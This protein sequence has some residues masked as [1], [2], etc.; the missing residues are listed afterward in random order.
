MSSPEPEIAVVGAG[1]FVGRR[2][3]EALAAAGVRVVACGRRGLELPGVGIAP[4]RV[5]IADAQDRAA[6]AR[7]VAGARVVV[8]AAGPLR[9]T[10]APVLEAALAAGAHYVDVGGEQAVLRSLYERY[11]SAVRK[12]GLVALPGAGLD[13]LIGDLAVAWAAAHLVGGAGDGDGAVGGAAGDGAVGGDGAG[14]G[15]PAV[16]DAPAPRLADA[17]PFD[18]IAVTYAFDDL[19]VSP[20]TQRAWFGVLGERALIWRRDRWEPARPGELRRVNAGPDLGGERA[21]IAHAGGDAITVPRHVAAH[22]VATYLSTTRRPS[23]GSALRLLSLAL[24]LLPRTASDVLVPYADPH[25]DYAR[26]RFAVIAQVRRD[27]AAAHVIVRGADPYR[28]TAVAAA[29]AARALAARGAG[30]VGMRAPGELFRGAPALRELAALA[31][32]VLE[33][34]FD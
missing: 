15:A 19:A 33:P 30:P 32:L 28:T 25:A 31:D 11:E 6:L 26:T 16:R 27:F 3:V 20:G 24:P 23:A 7:A 22:R 34:G 18:E 8:N 2:V 10:A 9:E 5:R 17:H 1:G 21:A 4:E 13:C 12:A 29:W 14:A